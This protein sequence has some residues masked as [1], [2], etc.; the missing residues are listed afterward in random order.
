MYVLY[1]TFLHC[2]KLYCTAFD[3]VAIRDIVLQLCC[4]R[5]VLHCDV[6][7]CMACSK[8]HSIVYG[9]LHYIA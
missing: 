3:Y 7:Y 4:A 8:L 1:C 9:T 6:L 5:V 2:I